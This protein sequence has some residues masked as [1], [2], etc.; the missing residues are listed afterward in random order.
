M[1]TYRAD[2]K[3]QN[4]GNFF[5]V[6]VKAGSMP[7]A[8]QNIQ[9]IYNPLIIQNLRQESNNS[10][11]SSG[12]DSEV[13]NGTVA[14]VLFC[15]GIWAFVSFAPWIMSGLGGALGTWIGEKVSG[16]SVDEYNNRTDDEG[17]GK[18]ALVFALALIMGGFGFV[19]GIEVKKYFDTPSSTPPAQVKTK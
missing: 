13:G 8:K 6:T 14:F 10:N 1:H 3:L 15:L 2:I 4:P 17:H 11:S 7:E 5:P 12:S 9:H 18:A 16:Q 19:K